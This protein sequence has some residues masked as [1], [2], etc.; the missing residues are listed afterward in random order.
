MGSDSSPLVLFDAVLEA[1]RHLDSTETLVVFVTQDVVDSLSTEIY[2]LLTSAQVVFEVVTETILMEE[3]PLTAIRRKKKSSLVTGIRL[4]KKRQIDAFISAGNTGALIAS[5]TLS[6][7]L[8]PGIQRPALL[9]VLPSKTGEV[10]VLDIGGNVSCKSHHLVQFAFLGAAYKSCFSPHSI[11]SV[12]LLNIGVESKKGTSEL[13]QAYLAL[14]GYALKKGNETLFL[15][16]VGNVEARE[17]FNGKL[18]VLVT[19]GFTGNVLLKTTEGISLFILDYLSQLN[20]RNPSEAQANSLHDLQMH[21]HYHEY[22][23]AVLCGVDGLVIKCHG[24]SSSRGVFNGIMGAVKL[25]RNGF[26]KQMKEIWH[27]AQHD[28][29]LTVS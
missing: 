20:Q 1:A 22:P 8:L 13:R 4:L 28:L 12:G 27:H 21:F 5:A 3:E 9:T 10:V 23:G 14:E 6:L 15:N 26:M 2:S 25:V 24:S 17:L 11:P 7:P 29:L 19:D 18:D 16:F